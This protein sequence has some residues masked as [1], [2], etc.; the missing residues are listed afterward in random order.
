MDFLSHYLQDYIRKHSNSEDAVLAELNRATYANVL[1]PQMLSGPEQGAFL[2]FIA[3]LTQASTALEIGTFT[4]YSAI[5]IAK[6]MAQNGRLT[7]IDIN[8]ELGPMVEKYLEKAA[9]RHK[10]TLL[11]G[12]AVAIIP[13]LNLSWDLV[14]IDADKANYSL[15]Y[16]LVFQNVRKGG[17]IIADNV[18]WSGK[19][20]DPDIQDKD[21]LA[22]RAF[23]EKIQKDVR[24]SN[25][26]L[27]IRDG[28]MLI[29]KLND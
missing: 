15:Y 1:M 21:T 11:H 3:A 29:Q 28:L 27:P 2:T 24:V 7:S 4:G 10:V 12:N 9:L 16:D 8:D 14:F 5:C 18:L 22:I 13:T 17:L 26:L 25:I 6:G 23:N 19:V 20:A